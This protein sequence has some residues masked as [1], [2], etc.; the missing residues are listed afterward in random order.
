MFCLKELNLT[1]CK[2]QDEIRL[3][4]SQL[5]AFWPILNSIC[6]FE[7]NSSFSPDDVSIVVL[8]MLKIRRNTFQRATVRYV[9]DY[10]QF[11]NPGSEQT[12]FY[13]VH[14]LLRYPKTYRVANSVDR[15]N[16]C[17]KNFTT[18]MD[19]CSGIFSIGKTEKII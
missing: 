4:Q 17:V 7:Q 8:E 5:P 19:F 14:K 1:D 15:D 2:N 13:P 16:I 11:E 12:Q 10:F 3:V 9:E 6:K 18:G